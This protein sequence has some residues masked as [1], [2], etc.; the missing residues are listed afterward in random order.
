M[1]AAV[2]FSGAQLPSA[3]DDLRWG[4]AGGDGGGHSRGKRYIV[5]VV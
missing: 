4:L 2:C 5:V 3:L 1:G